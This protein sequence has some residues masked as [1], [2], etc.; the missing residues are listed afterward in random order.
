MREVK[1]GGYTIGKGHPVRVVAEL[2]ICHRGD[3]ELALDMAAAATE[4]GADFVKFEMYELENVIT[5][6]YR[7]DN[8]ISFG[9]LKDGEVTENLYQAYVDGFISYK[10]AAKIMN[11]VGSK[12]VPYFA[13]VTSIDGAKFLM[14]NGACG[15]KLSSGEIDHIPLIRYCGENKIP[16]FIDS[17]K[18]YMWEVIRAVEE[19]ELAG[20]KDVIV[21]QNP[22]GYPAPADLIDLDRI[23][24]LE[25]ALDI[26]QGYTD[27]SPGRNSIMAAIGKGALVIEKPISPDKTRPY[28]EYAFSENLEDLADF[29]HEVREIDIARG[30]GRRLWSLE[31]MAANRLNR[32]GVV[33]AANLSAGHVLQEA[34]L[35]VARPGYGIRAEYVSDL[36]GKVLR[37]DMSVG[38]ALDWDAI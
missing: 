3:V 16:A 6:P 2:G 9:T 13:T 30:E 34:D 35:K 31:D 27:H 14:D 10:D 36:V 8:T 4:A 17:A 37:K 20:G 29:I 32:H 7:K 15:V 18:T 28:V 1:I 5:E 24:R 11:F 22:A 33:V 25:A 21:M 19:Y 26:P 12:N 38:E 23:S